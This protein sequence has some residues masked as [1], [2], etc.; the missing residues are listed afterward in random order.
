MFMRMYIDLFMQL[1]I[2]LAQRDGASKYE[3]TQFRG[4]SKIGKL[5]RARIFE[6]GKVTSIGCFPNKE[7]AAKAY[8]AR[9]RELGR[10]VLNFG[11]PQVDSTVEDDTRAATGGLTCHMVGS[12]MQVIDWKR[13][14]QSQA[15]H[16]AACAD[17]QIYH[18]TNLKHA[19][20]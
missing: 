16:S 4:V 2:G 5:Y 12:I 1:C 6:G 8:D 3:G 7:A 13:M 9:A 15:A 20:P 11:R 19:R 10:V 17:I 14:L 18:K